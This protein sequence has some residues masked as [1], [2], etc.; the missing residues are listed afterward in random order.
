MQ[1]VEHHQNDIRLLNLSGRFDAHTAEQV[2][3]F[4]HDK[5]EA[6]HRK[7]VLNMQNVDFIDSAGLRVIL[8][9]VRDLRDQHQGELNI[10]G[11]QPAVRR[12]FEISGLINVL[13]IFSDTETATVNLSP[14][15]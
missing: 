5:I 15:L 14:T 9:T 12:V 6:G 10:A 8:V 1:I 4:L 11:L 13:Q 2:E 7:F 3:T